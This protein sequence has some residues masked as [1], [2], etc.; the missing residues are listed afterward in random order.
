[1]IHHPSLDLLRR[2]VRQR[3]E[4]D[5]GLRQVECLR[6]VVL[7]RRLELAFGKAEVE[8]LDR[9]VG[10][11]H[12]VGRFE[13][14]V[15]HTLVVRRGKRLGDRD[16]DVEQRL[17]RHATGRYLCVERPPLDER[18][19]QKMG[20]VVL[21]DRE[22]GDDV[23]VVEGREGA[24]FPPETLE[25]RG[26]GRDLGWQDLEG[27]AAVE[28]RVAGEKDLAHPAFANLLDQAVVQ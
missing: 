24:R 12:D 20:L 8:D 6:D 25:P 7:L 13:V 23:R 22:D 1:M 26:I 4:N 21:L 2:H 27:D 17:E 28:P 5:A 15:D 11:D 18:H 10:V 9:A 14:A 16:G 3:A 19:R